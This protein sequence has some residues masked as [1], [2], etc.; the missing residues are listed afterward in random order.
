M[1]DFEEYIRQGEPRKREKG[2]AWQTAIG[3]Q[4]VDDLITVNLTGKGI[5]E[6][7][8]GK[9]NG[10]WKVKTDDLNN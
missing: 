7:K 9:R 2:Y 1:N 4:A 5:I 6:R 10:F 8:N 3:L